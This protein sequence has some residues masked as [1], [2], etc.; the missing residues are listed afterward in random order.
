MVKAMAQAVA[1]RACALFAASALV[2]AQS[3]PGTR[4]IA[5]GDLLY[6]GARGAHTKYPSV[7]S[8]GEVVGS[9][10]SV[11]S[12]P[13]ITDGSVWPAP[14]SINTGLPGSWKEVAINEAAVGNDCPFLTHGPT[15][16]LTDCQQACDEYP[17]C[18]LINYSP[19]VPD[20]VLRTCTNP[21]APSLTPYPSYN[22]YAVSKQSLLVDQV[23]FNIVATGFTHPYLLSAMGR[24]LKWSFPYPV[25]GKTYPNTAP[26]GNP[27]KMLGLCVNVLSSNTKLSLHTDESYNITIEDDSG[28]GGRLGAFASQLVAP[29][30][31]GAMRGLETFAQL[32][33]YNWTS[34]QYSI[35]RV[36]VVDAPRFPFRGVMLDTSRHFLSVP[37]IQDVL[38][39]MASL[40]MNAVH[41][42]L[43][44]EWPCFAVCTLACVRLSP[45]VLRR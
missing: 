25:N 39:M 40:K 16:N 45:L 38:D 13:D 8:T 7:K 20:C 5:T 26:S 35:A 2:F 32:M 6:T 21:Y 10:S 33:Q 34:G 37:V 1:L 31:Y 23:N 4:P 41:L 30:I 27:G 11:K 18:N 14:I 43:T 19:S 9:G 28:S 24:Y 29:T 36:A 44:G 3:P 15:S 22:V 42:H 12:T 17:A